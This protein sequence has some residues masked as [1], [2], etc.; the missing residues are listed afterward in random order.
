MAVVD[1]A[2]L[3]PVETLDGSTAVLVAV[4]V[5]STRL[6]DNVVLDVTPGGSEADLGIVVPAEESES[7][8]A[9]R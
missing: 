5:G 4:R 9:A 2:E 7:P 6:I 8:C 3:R 1:A